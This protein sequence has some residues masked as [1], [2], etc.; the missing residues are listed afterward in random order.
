VQQPWSQ[1]TPSRGPTS[2]KRVDKVKRVR[3]VLAAGES[4][5]SEQE[6]AAIIVSAQTL[7]IN[8]ETKIRE[9]L[10]AVSDD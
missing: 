1:H 10:L 6:R 7:R 4:P 5:L 8:R 9:I 3:K 2:Q